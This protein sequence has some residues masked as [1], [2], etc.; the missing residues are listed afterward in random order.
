MVA[1]LQLPEE[2][3]RSWSRLALYHHPQGLIKLSYQQISH[4]GPTSD[5]SRKRGQSTTNFQQQGAETRLPG[6]M[7]ST[8]RL[9]SSC[10]HHPAGRALTLGTT[11]D[12]LPL[13]QAPWQCITTDSP[14]DQKALICSKKLVFEVHCVV[15]LGHFSASLVRYIPATGRDPHKESLHVADVNAQHSCL[16]D[17]ISCRASQTL[18]GARSEIP[19]ARWEVHVQTISRHL[20][21][22]AALKKND[23]IVQ[24]MLHIPSRRVPTLNAVLGCLTF[25]KCT[26]QHPHPPSRPPIMTPLHPF[27]R[28][29]GLDSCSQAGRVACGK[30]PPHM[31][32]F[33]CGFCQPERNVEKGVY[34]VCCVESL[35]RSINLP[36]PPMFCTVE[37]GA[38]LATGHIDEIYM[39]TVYG[40]NS[41][42][43]SFRDEKSALKEEKEKGAEWKRIVVNEKGLER[44]N[45]PIPQSTLL[46]F[47]S[48]VPSKV[49]ILSHPDTLNL[50]IVA[51]EAPGSRKT[52]AIKPPPGQTRASLFLYEG[53]RSNKERSHRDREGLAFGPMPDISR[54]RGQLT[55]NFQQQDARARLPGWM[56]STCRPQST[57]LTI[58]LGEH[59]CWAPRWG[60]YSISSVAKWGAQFY[61]LRE[62]LA[63]RGDDAPLNYEETDAETSK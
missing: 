25:A 3:L 43:Q 57:A 9:Q 23:T 53:R 42:D 5:I 28:P 36:P 22:H 11:E 52:R 13:V 40:K 29:S 4:R 27:S 32:G 33:G 56:K 7:K 35:D 14:S 20:L 49:S 50:P 8:C 60:C 10:P 19:T 39:Y 38:S 59:A 54:K 48:K 31:E 47:P 21:C 6:L 2:R 37:A 12:L 45:K 30:H 63:S 17:W 24:S 58:P 62:Q 1:K 46:I 15:T 18:P 55:T 16:Q 41:M 61:T 51:G 44:M 26:G 34:N